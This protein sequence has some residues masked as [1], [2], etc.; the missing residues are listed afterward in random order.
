MRIRKAG[1][2]DTAQ[3]ANM[4]IASIKA[5]CNGHY[6][7]EQ[8]AAW[9][10]ALKP[11]GYE[12]AL[13][14]LAF[15]V[16]E[17]DGEILGFGMLDVAASEIRAIYVAPLASGRGVGSRLLAELEAL[18]REAALTRLMVHSTLNATGFY[19]R[20]GFLTLGPAAHNLP[21]GTALPCVK[22]RKELG[23]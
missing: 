5:L 17:D 21:D 8:I 4:H 16:A 6:S 20:R 19:E 15:L 14:S 13:Q 11:R 1:V 7:K 10:G 3:L 2:K 18:A 23:L 22:M 12:H 9:T